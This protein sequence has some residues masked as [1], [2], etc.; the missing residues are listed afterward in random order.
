[1]LPE[2]KPLLTEIPK[3]LGLD[4]RKMSKSYNNAILLG[5]GEESARKRVMQR[6]SSLLEFPQGSSYGRARFED[7]CNFISK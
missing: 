6:D 5:E 3:I 1:M 4:G 2:P 7:V